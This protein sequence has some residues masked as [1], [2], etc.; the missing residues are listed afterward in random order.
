MKSAEEKAIQDAVLAQLSYIAT[1]TSRT[2]ELLSTGVTNN[3]L[4]VSTKQ[5]PTDGYITYSFGATIGS[6]EVHNH[7]TN[8]M[9][10]EASSASGAKI[11]GVGVSRVPSGLFR[12]IPINNRTMTVY[13]TAGDFVG[14]VIVTTY[15]SGSGFTG[16]D[17]G[18]A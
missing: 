3:V 14:V 16:V 10:V 1:H 9:T 5:I 6:A 12:T 2:S 11:Q 18:A 13:G 4:E 8:S 15:R 7:G 17:G